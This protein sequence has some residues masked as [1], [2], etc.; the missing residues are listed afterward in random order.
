MTPRILYGGTFD[1]VHAGHLAVAAA[2]R[3]AL[4]APVAFVPAADP[5]HRAA[6]GATAE[7][8]AAML[9]L[10]VAGEPGFHVDRRELDRA[11]PSWTILTLEALRAEV[12]PRQ[13]LVWLIGD[14]AFLGLPTWHRWREL[15]GLA[16]LLVAVRP[17]HSLDAMPPELAAEVAGRWAGEPGTLAERPAGGLFRLAMPPHP[18]SAT[19]LRA[20]LRAGEDVA[21]WLPPAVAAYIARHGLYT[22]DPRHPGV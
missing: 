8:R 19:R 10:A 3:D 6:P 22:G 1:P 2:A 12:G 18:A 21:D 15:L 5:P 14:D 4:G 11:G 20:R 16:H 7:Q 17:G 13:P 9:A